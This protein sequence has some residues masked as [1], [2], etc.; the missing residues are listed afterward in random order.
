M[1]LNLLSSASTPDKESVDRGHFHDK[2][3]LFV[4]LCAY[5]R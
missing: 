2:K 4:S 5:Y 1:S 3:N